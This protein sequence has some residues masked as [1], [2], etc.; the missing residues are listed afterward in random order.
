MVWAWWGSVLGRR[1]SRRVHRD[2]DRPA[3][4]TRRAGL[5]PRLL[6]ACESSTLRDFR[7]DFVFPTSHEE[8]KKQRCARVSHG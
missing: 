6:R 4:S 8:R 7:S 2:L 1:P 5:T 3:H